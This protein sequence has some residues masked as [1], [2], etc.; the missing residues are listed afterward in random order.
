MTLGDT[1]NI[2]PFD[3]LAL[4]AFSK[5]KCVL[6]KPDHPTDN[7]G[8]NEKTIKLAYLIASLAWHLTSLLIA[9][10]DSFFHQIIHVWL[11]GQDCGGSVT[12]TTLVALPESV[13]TLDCW[14][15]DSLSEW[16]WWNHHFYFLSIQWVQMSCPISNRTT[17]PPGSG[18]ILH[19]PGRS[20]KG[21]T[22]SS[23]PKPS[24]KLRAK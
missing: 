12:E 13:P 4:S 18:C 11:A 24:G 5:G 9:S 8:K 2:C 7:N 22:R 1:N 19:L 14:S 6:Y 21:Q 20:G 23:H 15:V 17:R 3:V 10:D 16:F